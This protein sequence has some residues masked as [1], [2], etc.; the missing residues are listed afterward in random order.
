MSE[1]TES[2]DVDAIED[3]LERWFATAQGDMAQT[4]LDCSNL[5][6]EV[7]RLQAQIPPEGSLVLVPKPIADVETGSDFYLP[8][9]DVHR[10]TQASTVGGDGPRRVV[11]DSWD[12]WF[13]E[14][15]EVYVE[16]KP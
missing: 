4:V 12:G 11:Y 13:A 10:V 1:N 5:I 9:M 2:I 16:W 15:A 7:E 8:G 3:R 6:A 14:D